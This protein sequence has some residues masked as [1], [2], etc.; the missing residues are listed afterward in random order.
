VGRTYL[1]AGHG[2][3]FAIPNSPVYGRVIR[4]GRAYVGIGGTPIANVR[5]WGSS[6]PLVLRFIRKMPY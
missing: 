3:G 5:A 4:V 1:K 2:V 6:W